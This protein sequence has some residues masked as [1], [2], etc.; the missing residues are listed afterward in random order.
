MVISEV[1]IGRQKDIDQAHV[2]AAH[3][4]T[5]DQ[6]NK[7][8]YLPIMSAATKGLGSLGLKTTRPTQWA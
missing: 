8:C 6:K 4:R 2:G 1:G 5:P 3:N 7:R